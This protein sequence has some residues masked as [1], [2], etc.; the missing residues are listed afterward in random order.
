MCHKPFSTGMERITEIKN[1][2]E[3]QSLPKEFLA[4]NPSELTSLILW[5][6]KSIPIER[7]TASQVLKSKLLPHRI[8]TDMR[9]LKKILHQDMNS[10]TLR[11]VIKALMQRGVEVY[12]DTNESDRVLYDTDYVAALK[13]K[14]QVRRLY[15]IR[16]PKSVVSSELQSILNG[17]N[18]YKD[19]LVIPLHLLTFVSDYLSSTFQSYGAINLEPSLFQS[20]HIRSHLFDVFVCNPTYLDK[21]GNVVSLSSDL[22]RPIAQT[23]SILNP[24]SMQLY[25]IG[26][27]YV[28]H[29][30][31]VPKSVN[32]AVYCVIYRTQRQ[33]L[34]NA[35]PLAVPQISDNFAVHKAAELNNFTRKNIIAEQQVLL[36]VCQLCKGLKSH[37]PTLC[38]RLVDYRILDAII[39]LAELSYQY[40][41]THKSIIA[42]SNQKNQ[43]KNP[44]SKQNNETIKEE[45]ET[46][47]M[48]EKENINILFSRYCDFTSFETAKDFFSPPSKYDKTSILDNVL[49]QLLVYYKILWESV[50]GVSTLNESVNV[51][52]CQNPFKLLQLIE[53]AFYNS[54]V[55]ANIKRELA[56]HN[57]SSTSFADSVVKM[58]TEPPVKQGAD[59]K[60]SQKLGIQKVEIDFKSI[61]MPKKNTGKSNKSKDSALSGSKVAFSEKTHISN[62]PAQNDVF[63]KKLEMIVRQFDLSVSHLRQVLGQSYSILDASC[64]IAGYSN[65]KKLSVNSILEQLGQFQDFSK[66]SHPLTNSK[67]E[68]PDVLVSN[69][70]NDIVDNFSSSVF[71]IPVRVDLFQSLPVL[72]SQGNTDTGTDTGPCH[73]TRNSN[74]PFNNSVFRFIVEVQHKFDIGVSNKLSAK[75]K[76]SVHRDIKG[77]LDV[78]HNIVIIEGGHFDSLLDTTTARLHGVGTQ[79]S[80]VAVGAR[81]RIDT[82]INQLLKYDKK[83]LLALSKV[84]DNA[85]SGFNVQSSL[86]SVLANHCLP[87]VVIISREKPEYNESNSTNPSQTNNKHENRLEHAC[88]SDIFEQ[89]I[90]ALLRQFNIRVTNEFHEL[91]FGLDPQ[92][93]SSTKQSSESIVDK[94]WHTFFSEM[95]LLSKVSFCHRYGIPLVVVLPYYSQPEVKTV[96]QSVNWEIDSNIEVYPRWLQKRQSHTS[97]QGNQTLRQGSNHIGCKYYELAYTVKSLLDQYYHATDNSIFKMCSSSHSNF[98]SNAR[99]LSGIIDNDKSSFNCS[100]INDLKPSS[101]SAMTISSK[102]VQS[103]DKSVKS[104]KNFQPNSSFISNVNYTRTVNLK[105]IDVHSIVTMMSTGTIAGNT[106]IVS[107]QTGKSK[108]VNV[109]KVTMHIEKQIKS[110]FVANILQIRN[111]NS[112][113]LRLLPFPTITNSPGGMISSPKDLDSFS[114]NEWGDYRV[115]ACDISYLVI[116][117][118]TVQFFKF[119]SSTGTSQSLAMQ[120]FCT[121]FETSGYRRVLKQVLTELMQLKETCSQQFIGIYLFS[122]CDNQIDLLTYDVHALHARKFILSHL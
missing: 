92:L 89:F 35:S 109:K 66:L 75:L 81:V 55:I 2:R 31:E 48:K 76:R 51:D 25:N 119:I 91:I 100:V 120:E 114:E 77:L 115:L 29:N 61:G 70:W 62:L 13:N 26:R 27:V 5:L 46:L 60:T 78:Y 19:A 79:V 95:P 90:L 103:T 97:H 20:N 11:N 53:E 38:I 82:L 58:H 47:S 50:H 110:F 7:P 68:N 72:H 74:H 65:D 45:L 71:P 41:S 69:G 40:Y 28:N 33:S 73:V 122:T 44:I 9:Y 6:V 113:E 57:K 85:K 93:F 24:S 39:Q 87:Q 21:C 12:R 17:I 111:S 15:P 118:F 84:T 3:K 101:I 36:T 80:W 22:I 108:N 63:V 104:T 42:D 107:S 37:L 32:E 43:P 54:P 34:V 18:R 59:V 106:A 94:S 8:D 83:E 67:N 56:S 86:S 117:G 49:D 121:F 4:Y 116:R 105:I 23:V 10:D 102:D 99:P 1:L 30:D 16:S 14:L 96:N 52:V 98:L 88:N 112:I 64:K